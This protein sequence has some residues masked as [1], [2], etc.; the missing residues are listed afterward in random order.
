MSKQFDYSKHLR[1]FFSSKNMGI[2][3]LILGVTVQFASSSSINNSIV[4]HKCESMPLSL[5][6]WTRDEA[7][8]FFHVAA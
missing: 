7:L 6:C 8:R 5:G 1:M 2:N 3:M 4:V